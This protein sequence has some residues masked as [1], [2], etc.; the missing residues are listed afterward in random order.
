MSNVQPNIEATI[1]IYALGVAPTWMNS[2]QSFV[3]SHAIENCYILLAFKMSWK[4][5]AVVTEFRVPKHFHRQSCSELKIYISH[6][7]LFW[8]LAAFD[9]RLPKP[10]PKSTTCTITSGVLQIRLS[11]TSFYS[12]RCKPS[13]WPLWS[14]VPPSNKTD[15]W[16]C[17]DCS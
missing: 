9:I 8:F 13:K 2:N 15:L 10:R 14:T 17:N 6:G 4:R 5:L 3:N 11:L 1:V 12:I 7:T 16:A